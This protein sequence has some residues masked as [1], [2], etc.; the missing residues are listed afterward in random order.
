MCIDFSSRHFRPQAWPHSPC[1]QCPDRCGQKK[2]SEILKWSLKWQRTLQSGLCSKPDH[3]FDIFFGMRGFRKQVVN[4][5][6]FRRWRLA[7]ARNN[8]SMSLQCAPV[9]LRWMMLTKTLWY[10]ILSWVRKILQNIPRKHVLY[11]HCKFGFISHYAEHLVNH[12][13]E[14]WSIFLLYLDIGPSKEP[15]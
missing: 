7:E 10:W 9:V 6:A 13:L 11:L 12:Y 1:G 3:Q 14:T 15:I 4:D 2:Q 8:R 5:R